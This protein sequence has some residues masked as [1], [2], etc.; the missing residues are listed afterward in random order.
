MVWFMGVSD[1]NAEYV[2][3]GIESTF[4]DVCERSFEANDPFADLTEKIILG[5]FDFY[6]KETA[7]TIL[8]YVAWDVNRFSAQHKIE[9]PLDARVDPL[10]EDI[11]R[12]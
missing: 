10:I 2:I 6:I 5:R 9:N 11:L 12:K 8:R 4:R 3:Q 7:A 1:E